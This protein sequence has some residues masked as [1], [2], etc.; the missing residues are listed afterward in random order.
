MSVH[1]MNAPIR[2]IVEE[3]FGGYFDDHDDDSLAEVLQ[4]QEIV[5]ES[6]QRNGQ[7]NTSRTTPNANLQS[8][9]FQDQNL[10][11]KRAPRSMHVNTQL[12][13]DEAIAKELQDMENQLVAIS[14]DANNST[15]SGRAPTVATTSHPRSTPARTPVQAPRDDDIDPDNMTYEELQQLGETIGTQSRGLSD[16]LIARLPKSTYKA[17]GLFSRKDKHEECIICC[18]KY[19]NKEKLIILP[20]NHK[21]HNTCVTKWLK[22]NKTCPVCGKEVFGS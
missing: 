20:C 5:Y 7:A 17:G 8:G 22:I 13:I 18:M 11:D 14:L 12:A 19:E 15:H 16:K 9:S 10:R 6:F 2:Y 3:N 1:Y 21:Y 4:D